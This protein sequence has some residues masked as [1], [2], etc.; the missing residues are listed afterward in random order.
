MIFRKNTFTSEAMQML[1]LAQHTASSLNSEKVNCTHLLAAV[2]RH[3][4]ETVADVL[5]KDISGWLDEYDINWNS[6][7]DEEN[8]LRYTDDL[9]VLLLDTAEDTPLNFIR[10]CFP[11]QPVG[12]AELA[13]I[14]L[15]EPT[16]E[17]VDIITRYGVTNDAAEYSEQLCFNYLSC[18]ERHSGISSRERLKKCVEMGRRFSDYMNAR[19]I[20]QEKTIDVLSSLLVDFWYNGNNRLPLSILLLSRA[21]GGKSFFTLVMQEA[22]VEL[23]LQK[24]VYP[25]LDMASFTNNEAA[26]SEL[27]GHNRSYKE[28]APGILYDSSCKNRRGM[29]VFENIDHGCESAGKI[30]TALT[31]NAAH[32]KF[33][34]KNLRM[35]MNVLVFT[36]TL[37]ETQYTFL[38]QNAS[39]TPDAAQLN[40]VLDS[41]E[42]KNSGYISGETGLI[43]SMNSLLVLEEPD[44]A[45]LKKMIR[46]RISGLGELLQKEYRISLVCQN[47]GALIDLLLQSSPHTLSPKEL[48]AVISGQLSGLSRSAIRYPEIESIEI[49]CGKLP[50]YPHDISRRT[51]RGDH[52]VFNR[53]ERCDGRTYICEFSEIKYVTRQ[54]IDFGA[55]RI[56]RPK[57]LSLNDIVG[58]DDLIMELQDALDFITGRYPDANIPPPAMGYI[59]AGAPGTGKTATI[60]ALASHC[61]VPVFF[62]GSSIYADAAKLNDLFVKAKKTAPCLVVFDEFD[63]IGSR[64]SSPWLRSAVNTMLSQLDGVEENAK[65]VVLA[66]TNYPEAIDP[67]LRRPGRFSRVITVGMPSPEAREIYIR[68]FEQKYF[69]EL[70]EKDRRFLVN[71]TDNKTIAVLKSIMELGLRSSIRSGKALNSDALE[72]AYNHIVSR[73]SSCSRRSIG[74][75]EENR[76]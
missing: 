32:N 74:F 30:L 28:A 12:A 61:D 69:F 44:A 56:E 18:R 67:A 16:E 4:P 71:L 50:D 15:K 1:K 58:L 53:H 51:V 25:A 31:R 39:C 55:Y 42:Q 8:T 21:G 65:M 27:C 76:Q 41:K 37:S 11:G 19:I 73:E 26:V 10:E 48:D 72:R 35:P 68:K 5:G 20:G 66:S 43:N 23:G 75:R 17:I 9:C 63:S 62:A 57:N 7:A 3:A 40:G 70:T 14:L 47:D 59:L 29:L 6:T 22:F 33:F 49:C 45:C 46:N 38:V 34:E 2:T 60:S 54:S 36:R 64:E 52:L 13:F 24:A